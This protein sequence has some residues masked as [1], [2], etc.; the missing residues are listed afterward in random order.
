MRN[1][2]LALWVARRGRT[3]VRTLPC[4]AILLRIPGRR[5]PGG[6]IPMWCA[7][8]V[9]I[10]SRWVARLRW[11]CP[12]SSLLRWIPMLRRVTLLWRVLAIWCPISVLPM[13]PK[14]ALIL[15]L[16]SQSAHTHTHTHRDRISIDTQTVDDSRT[17]KRCECCKMRLPGEGAYT[18]LRHSKERQRRPG[19]VKLSQFNCV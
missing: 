8:L 19:F 1:M 14:Q 2:A 13:G 9:S 15:I 11:V 18:T 6:R 4:V 10:P 16:P 7:L 17:H 5:V 3:A 12:G